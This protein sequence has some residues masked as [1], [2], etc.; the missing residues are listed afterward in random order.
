VPFGGGAARAFLRDFGGVKAGQRVL[1]VG[2]SGTVGTWAVQIARHLGAEVTGVCSAAN[3]DLVRSLGAHHAVDYG[4]GSVV[5]PG[6]R[7]DLIFDTV[8]VTTFAGCKDSLTE[9]GLYL[10]LNSGP[11]EMAQAL[12]TAFG[13]GRRV[14]Y[15][16]SANTRE[17]LETLASLI[18]AGGRAARRRPGVPDGADR[19]GPPPRRGATPA[20][21]RRARR[22]RGDLSRGG[23]RP[24]GGAPGR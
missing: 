21:Q 12:L 2:A 19:R 23:T 22:L 17:G 5:E 1:V 4:L 8:G 20:R 13:R 18:G 10:P 3:L 15:A 24:F 9:R 14:R 6:Q 11:R 16:V 7:Y